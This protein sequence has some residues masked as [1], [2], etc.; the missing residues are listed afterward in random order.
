MMALELK[1][2]WLSY[3]QLRLSL[4]TLPS[5]FFVTLA[6]TA[7]APHRLIVQKQRRR[8]RREVKELER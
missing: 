3:H 8:E 2:F 5:K 4:H 1:H 7:L 6:V